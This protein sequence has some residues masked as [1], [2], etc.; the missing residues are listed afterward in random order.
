MHHDLQVD[1]QTD[2]YGVEPFAAS[3]YGWTDALWIHVL[4]TQH[5]PCRR[6]GSCC[7]RS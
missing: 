7:N 6:I 2:C 3:W 1:S 5:S 4:S